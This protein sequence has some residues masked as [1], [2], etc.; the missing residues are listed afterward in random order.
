MVV[1]PP[2]ARAAWSGP[3]KA[4]EGQVAGFDLGQAGL[5]SRGDDEV[6]I[7]LEGPAQEGLGVGAV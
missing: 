1:V 6:E 4:D 3:E 5:V 2:T 7:G